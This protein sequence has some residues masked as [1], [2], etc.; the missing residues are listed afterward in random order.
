M[1]H[2]D[3][4]PSERVEI[5]ICDAGSLCVTPGQRR[6]CNVHWAQ[7]A[8]GYWAPVMSICKGCA[9]KGRKMTRE[10]PPVPVG[11]VEIVF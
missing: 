5:G 6:K 10:N 8:T 2:D 1:T 4:H 11:S 7:A 3:I 9:R